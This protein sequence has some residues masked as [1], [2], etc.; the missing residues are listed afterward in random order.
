MTD[1]EKLNAL[2][3]DNPVVAATLAAGGSVLDCVLALDKINKIL[4]NKVV[5]LLQ[6]AP[7][8]IRVGGK[9]LVWRCP[10]NM[11]PDDPF[12]E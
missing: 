8:K 11:I 1:E 7:R 2:A 6:I 3:R 12:Y 9:D 10:D 4:S 5:R